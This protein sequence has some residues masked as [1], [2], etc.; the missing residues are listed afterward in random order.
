MYRIIIQWNLDLTNLYLTKTSIQRTVFFA[1]VI[2]KYMKK[3]LDITKPRFNERIWTVANDF[4]K[5]RFHCIYISFSLMWLSGMLVYRSKRRCLHTN[6]TQFPED[7]T[8]ICFGKP[9]W[10]PWRHVK[11]IYCSCDDI[12]CVCFYETKKWCSGFS[13]RLLRGNFKQVCRVLTFLFL[14]QVSNS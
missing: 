6:W 14:R 11:T 5:S 9:I 2:K 12:N 13:I 8:P 10:L 7:W 3:N 1:P 4:V